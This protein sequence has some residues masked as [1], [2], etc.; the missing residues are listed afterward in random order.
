MAQATLDSPQKTADFYVA[1]WNLDLDNLV[2]LFLGR[3]GLAFLVVDVGGDL[4]GQSVSVFAKLFMV[5]VDFVGFMAVCTLASV[6]LKV[7]QRPALSVGYWPGDRLNRV[8]QESNH[9][10]LL[11]G[12]RLGVDDGRHSVCAGDK[13]HCGG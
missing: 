1:R 2:V 8:L 7:V 12:D 9:P 11:G 6:H 3:E 13:W 5:A 10:L 4:L